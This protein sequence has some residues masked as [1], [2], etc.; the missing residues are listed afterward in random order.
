MEFFDNYKVK[1]LL[2]KINNISIKR[3]VRILPIENYHS[4]LIV[5]NERNDTLIKSIES[6]FTTSKITQLYSRIE[7]E[8]TLTNS[9]YVYTY[10]VSDLGFSKIKN[11]RLLGLVNTNFDLIID[12]SN[13]ITEFNYF[14]KI[15]KASLKI[16]NLHSTNNYLYDILVERGNS[17]TDFIDNITLQINT[18]SQ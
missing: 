6:I 1:M 2:R 14:I 3:T 17:D 13:K 8:D 15:S 10:H 5:Q 11:E 16:G 9:N 7:K 12:F 18:L 4:I